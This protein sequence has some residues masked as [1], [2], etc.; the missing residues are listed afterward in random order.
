MACARPSTTTAPGTPPRSGTRRRVGR[1]G[2]PARVAALALVAT[3]LFA[4]TC[5][6]ARPVTH[7][8]LVPGVP[9]SADLDGD[10]SQEEILVDTADFSLSFRDGAVVYHSREEWRIVQ[11]VLGDTDRDG[12]T[13][14]VTLLDSEDGR[15]LG[16]F[17]YFAG[18]FRERLV[19]Q[20]ISPAP[21][22]IEIVD[23]SQNADSAG[24][25]ES[26]AA[27][28]DVIVLVQEPA[29]GQTAARRTLLRWNGFGFTRIKAAAGP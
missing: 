11:A 5:T 20:A 10:G 14:V 7:D 12:L 8:R 28:G 16:L 23:C 13:E 21:I 29:A 19:T 25:D 4:F 1:L 22:A 24:G 9:T 18:E 15:H 6:D 3:A 26:A 27:D 2:A 17:A